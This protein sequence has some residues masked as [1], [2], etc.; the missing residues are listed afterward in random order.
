MGNP[1]PRPSGNVE[2]PSSA[3]EV[4]FVQ[5][6]GRLELITRELLARP[7]RKSFKHGSAG[8]FIRL[9]NNARKGFPTQHLDTITMHR[10]P[11]WT[12]VLVGDGDVVG[13]LSA[14]RYM[15]HREK[16]QIVQVGAMLARILTRDEIRPGRTQWQSDESLKRSARQRTGIERI[17]KRSGFDTGYHTLIVRQVESK[18]MVRIFDPGTNTSGCRDQTDAAA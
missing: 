13:S 6:D 2:S 12:R 15:N 3:H 10:R 8:E 16:Q 5:Y 9:H 14:P 17:T 7:S 4:T 11:D 18:R 1:L